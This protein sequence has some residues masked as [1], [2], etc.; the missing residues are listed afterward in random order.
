MTQLEVTKGL[1][2]LGLAYNYQYTQAEC[3][4]YY[5]FLHEF[6]YQTFVNAVKNLIRKSKFIPKVSDLIEECNNCKE[7]TKIAVIEFMKDRGYFN[8]NGFLDD[9]QASRNYDK[10]IMFMEKGIVPDWLQ[11]DINKYYKIMTQQTIGHQE[12]KL[13]G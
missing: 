7:T 11:N 10:T 2:Y 9:K 6:N 3:E 1:T 13:I 12:Q 4:L 5:D 8:Q